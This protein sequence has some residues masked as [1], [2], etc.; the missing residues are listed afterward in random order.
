MLGISAGCTSEATS[1]G[2]RRGT[3]EIV[4]TTRPCAP[5]PTIPASDADGLLP[6]GI[7][8]PADASLVSAARSGPTRTVVARTSLAP[9]AAHA[10][11]LRQIEGAGYEV[12]RLDDE[13]IEAEIYFSMP[14]GSLGVVQQIRARCPEGSTQT[15]VSVV[16]PGAGAP[17]TAPPG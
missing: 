4:G 14:G 12:L 9:S 16:E 2:A 15:L 3:S 10:M 13:V 7:E 1:P 6:Q 17:T 5:P 8:L 11:Y